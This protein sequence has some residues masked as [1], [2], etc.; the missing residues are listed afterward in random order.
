MLQREPIQVL[1]A[2]VVSARMLVAVEHV[3]RVRIADYR[4]RLLLRCG[5][6]GVLRV[7]LLSQ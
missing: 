6:A 5:H 3:L 1:P 4:R 2:L 7:G